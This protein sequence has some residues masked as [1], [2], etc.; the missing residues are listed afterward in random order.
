MEPFIELNLYRPA[1]GVE[2]LEPTAVFLRTRVACIR[3]HAYRRCFSAH[4]I[5]DMQTVT[6]VQRTGMYTEEELNG[7]CPIITPLGSWDSASDPLMTL[8]DGSRKNS[9]YEDR[10]RLAVE[11]ERLR[12]AGQAIYRVQ[13]AVLI[14][15][16][17]DRWTH[18][19]VWYITTPLE[20]LQTHIRGLQTAAVR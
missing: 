20:A 13:T 2:V 7:L 8:P 10:V 3:P 6:E 1:S 15:D 18:L 9:S 12:F 17:R 14:R 19:Q 4:R 5:V 16:A 11:Q